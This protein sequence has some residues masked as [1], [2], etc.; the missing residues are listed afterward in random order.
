[1]F[2][3]VLLTIPLLLAAPKPK[4]PV[5]EL[6]KARYA[7]LHAQDMLW[8]CETDTECEKAWDNLQKA[9]KNLEEVKKRRD[10]H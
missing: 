4:K 7:V 9:L 2:A 10:R 5:S 6:Q 3:H 8:V 1:M